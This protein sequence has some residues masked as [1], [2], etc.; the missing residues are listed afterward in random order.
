MKIFLIA[1]AAKLARKFLLH[2]W[3]KK[4]NSHLQADQL[5]H[6]RITCISPSSKLSNIFP[7]RHF[8][9]QGQVKSWPN[10]QGR[11]HLKRKYFSFQNNKQIILCPESRYNWI[12]HKQ[13]EDVDRIYSKPSQQPDQLTCAGQ[14]HWPGSLEIGTVGLEGGKPL[15]TTRQHCSSSPAFGPAQSGLFG[16]PNKGHL[17]EPGN[18]RCMM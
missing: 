15:G 18:T 6:P 13:I 7:C 16:H 11:S 10:C 12:G 17:E 14:G 1:F 5:R 3:G 4:K 2:K 8:L 9:S